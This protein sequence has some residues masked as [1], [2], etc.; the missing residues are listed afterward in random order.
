MFD[1]FLL[2]SS[3][4]SP[5]CNTIFSGGVR[6]LSISLAPDSEACVADVVKMWVLPHG[7][8]ELLSSCLS[9]MIPVSHFPFVPYVCGV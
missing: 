9:V 6:K 2:L 3:T 7:D 4:S 8:E 1:S 5:H